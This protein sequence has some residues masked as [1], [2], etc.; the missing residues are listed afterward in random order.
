MI[1]IED[2]FIPIH[3]FN[4]LQEYCDNNLF[5]IISYP[6]KQFSVLKTPEHIIDYLRI[7]NYEA[8]LSFIRSA[9]KGFDNE[10]RIH[11]DNIINGYK[12]EIATILYVNDE[13]GVTNN[14]TAFWR[15]HK[16][17]DVLPKDCSEEEFNDIISN[18]SND[19]SKWKLTDYIS[20]K[21]NRL[22]TYDANYFHSKF[23]NEIEEGIRKVVVTFYRKKNEQERT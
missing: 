20:S 3:N 15:H 21:P 6:D 8:T 16:F 7:D 18:D 14:G 5:E 12:T 22:L 11:S 1:K 9:Y 2:N 19:I 17:G 10:L 23:P 13:V 4:K